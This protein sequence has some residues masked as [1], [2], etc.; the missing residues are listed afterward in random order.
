MIEVNKSFT[1][2]D[3]PMIGKEI[4]FSTSVYVFWD[5]Q[6]DGSIMFH[7]YKFNFEN[8]TL[9]FVKSKQSND[10]KSN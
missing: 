6:P 10:G 1:A 8:N 5:M 9:E 3:G 2:I 4:M 7:D